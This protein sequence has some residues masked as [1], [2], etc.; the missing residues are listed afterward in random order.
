MTGT[1]KSLNLSVWFLICNLMIAIAF[2]CSI[3]Q[4]KELPA[5]YDTSD[6]NQENNLLSGI[7]ENDL[8]GFEWM[9]KPGSYKFLNNSIQISPPADSDFFNDPGS[10]KVT[11]TAP[12]LYKLVKGDFVA[13]ALVRPSFKDIWN[14]CA[15]M[16]YQESTYWGKL[17][18]ENSDA[19]GP[20]VVTVVTKETSDDSNGPIIHDQKS[21]WLRIARKGDL[22]AMYWSLNG[23][24]YKMARLFS[25]PPC[26]S[27]KIGMVA[28]CPAGA[29][30]IHE[31]NY[32]SIEKK[33]L[34]DL[35]KG[36]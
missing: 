12:M 13:T 21:I 10:S 23:L 3:K 28:Q 34:K 24:D 27:I 7:N 29:S 5:V 16:V 31:F 36:I 4:E 32:F 26:D 35:R 18:F 14:A 6:L 20:S 30:V 22:Y 19:T 25:M 2:N 15:L 11:G 8:Q 17:C 1:S 33:S 9:N